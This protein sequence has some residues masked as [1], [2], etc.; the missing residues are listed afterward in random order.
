MRQNLTT[1]QLHT[2]GNAGKCWEIEGKI[3]KKVGIRS[4]THLKF[5]QRLFWGVYICRNL[6]INVYY[7]IYF[8]NLYSL[9]EFPG[10]QNF[11]FPHFPG[12]RFL[13]LLTWEMLSLTNFQPYLQTCFF[14][15]PH[16]PGNVGNRKLGFGKLP[17]H[18]YN[19]ILNSEFSLNILMFFV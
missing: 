15:F 8:A 9:T 19:P 14:Y 5:H 2:L 11:Y 13:D 6:L 3:F 16:F 17:I 12:N 7:L 1:L 10:K 4:V 18:S